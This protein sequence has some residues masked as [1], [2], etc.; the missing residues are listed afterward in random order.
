MSSIFSG[1]YSEGSWGNEFSS[2]YRSLAE[3]YLIYYLHDPDLVCE[4]GIHG[5]DRL[6]MSLDLLYMVVPTLRRETP[7]SATNLW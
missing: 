1:D 7:G 2:L 5:V 6:M 3:Q 4:Q